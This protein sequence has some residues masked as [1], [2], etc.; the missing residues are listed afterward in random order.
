M[1]GVKTTGVSKSQDP[2]QVKIPQSGHTSCLSRSH[3]RRR[4]NLMWAHA[5][6][7]LQRELGNISLPVAQLTSGQ[8]GEST[9]GPKSGAPLAYI[10]GLLFF[11]FAMDHR[12]IVSGPRA[13][14]GL[15]TH[16]G[17]TI[18]SESSSN[19]NLDLLLLPL[20]SSND[21]EVRPSANRALFGMIPVPNYCP[22]LQWVIFCVFQE[23]FPTM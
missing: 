14:C 9:P 4:E 1:D 2:C 13:T 21:L 15:R 7:K 11:W 12:W 5:A 8:R 19:L 22:T 20:D 17:N 10:S 16:L 18:K 6:S 3:W 23:Y